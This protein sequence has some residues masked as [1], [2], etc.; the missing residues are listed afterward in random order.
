MPGEKKSKRKGEGGGG[1][2]EKQYQVIALTSSNEAKNLAS[3]FP[4]LYLIYN[5]MKAFK[6]KIKSTIIQ[7]L[8]KLL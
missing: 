2:K 8:N 6:I 4:R 1:G 3:K 5:L 7:Q